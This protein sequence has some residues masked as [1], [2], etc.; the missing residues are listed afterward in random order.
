MVQRKVPDKLGIHPADLHHHSRKVNNKLMLSLEASNLHQHQ[1]LKSSIGT[2]LKKKMMKKKKS[3]KPKLSELE[4]VRPHQ[5]NSP[6]PQTHLGASSSSTP[7]YMKSTSSSDA[8]KDKCQV[9]SRSPQSVSSSKCKNTTRMSKSGGHNPSRTGLTST[10]TTTSL[11]LVRALTK[12]PSFKPARVSSSKKCPQVVFCESGL[13]VQR[14]TCSSTLK[15]SKFPCY[16]E[17]NPGDTTAMKVCPYTYCSLNGHHH[18]Q[19]P[20]LKSFLSARRLSMKANRN[21]RKG[22]SSPCPARPTGVSLAED[23]PNWQQEKLDFT[24]EIYCKEGAETAKNCSLDSLP[25]IGPSEPTHCFNGAQE[26]VEEK[27]DLF[28]VIDY[29]SAGESDMDWEGIVESTNHIEEPDLEVDCIDVK[30]CDVIKE[31]ISL[32]K[33]EDKASCSSDDFVAEKMEQESF[34]EES[35]TSE[36]CSLSGEDSNSSISCLGSDFKGCDNQPATH[37]EDE[38]ETTQTRFLVSDELTEEEICK[39]FSVPYEEKVILQEDDVMTPMQ[40]NHQESK[41]PH[42]KNAVPNQCDT[43][44]SESEEATQDESIETSEDGIQKPPE[45]VSDQQI[46]NVE[47]EWS[48]NIKTQKTS[49]VPEEQNAGIEVPPSLRRTSRGHNRLLI[50]EDE[51]R[52]FNPRGPNFLPLKPVP[53]A[54]SVDLKHQMM[55]ER[56]NSEEWMIDY[57]LQQAVSKLGP[58]RRKKVALLVEAFETISPIPKCEPRLRQNTNLFPPSRFIQACN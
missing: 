26:E 42:G 22:C 57:A 47:N 27:G 25:Q 56:K 53:E 49:K 40:E 35:V 34:D 28:P 31:P 36:A 20:P 4:S 43:T 29:S 44:S 54:E 15:D 58:V 11:K 2:D 10:K 19:L 50:E 5:R 12:A 17:L 45:N 39:D 23:V 38:K 18:L 7:N 32:L 33:A 51:P 30:A 46:Y 3:G 1:D 24:V 9:S 13:D 41:D 14:A 16:L 48:S 37:N 21:L 55:N 8:R 52:D 6:S